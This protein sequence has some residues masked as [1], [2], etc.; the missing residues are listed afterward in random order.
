MI[1]N[2]N[3]P[4]EKR[5]KVLIINAVKEV[6]Q[7][8]NIAFLEE[9]HIQ[10]IFNAYKKFSNE[11]GFSKAVDMEEILSHKASL[12]VSLYISNVENNEERM[13][14]EDA[15]QAW[16]KSSENLKQSMNELFEVLG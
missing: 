8:K 10:K 5:G 1:T 3:K 9:K 7:D 15:I 4:E 14:L 13:S 11:P 2:N 12:N 16:E 6:R